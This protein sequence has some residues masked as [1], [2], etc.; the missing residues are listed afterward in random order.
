MLIRLFREARWTTSALLVI[1]L[2][3]LLSLGAYPLTDTTEARYGEMVRKMVELGD[4]VTPWFDYG[5]PFWGKPPLAF[6]LSAASASVLGVNEFSLRL[7]S[8]LLGLG[9]L[10]LVGR[11]AWQHGGPARSALAMLVLASSVLF[12]V[13]SGA[14][15]TDTALAFSVTLAMTAYWLGVV[16][17]SRHSGRWRMVFFGALGLGLLA[18]GP[19]G[20]VLS[21]APILFWA[22]PY[23][24][25]RASLRCMPW[26]AGLL[27]MST[28]AIPWYLLAEHRTP[29]FLQYFLV[30]ENFLRFVDPL[31]SGDR[32]GSVHDAPHGYIWLLWVA[33]ILPWSVV[34]PVIWFTTRRSVLGMS[35]NRHQPAWNAY[36]L[37]FALAPC[38]FFTLA[39]SVLPT[40]VLPALP[41]FALWTAN[42]IFAYGSSTVLRRTAISAAILPAIFVGLLPVLN[43]NVAADKS[44]YQLLTALPVNADV[45]YFPKRPFSAQ[46]YSNGHAISAA[47]IDDLQLIVSKKPGVYIAISTQQSL[48]EELKS[49][50]QMIMVAGAKRE[51]ALWRPAQ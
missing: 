3:R 37:C 5:V 18:K 20:L 33:S 24:Y 48:P 50:Y 35:S 2:L 39:G 11:L 9:M 38:L 46:F 23:E 19:V 7:P 51:Y 1:L 22:V 32:Y 14:V 36:L 28:I 25:L 49:G 44:Q 6:W 13:C 40:Y 43:T 16:S 47:S 10:G 42:Q 15:L 27:T 12:F 17:P 45:V 30:G 31:W 26:I 29:G 34:L 8:Y 4:W 41:T 21:A